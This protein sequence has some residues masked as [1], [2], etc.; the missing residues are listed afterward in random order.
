VARGSVDG[1]AD[2]QGAQE[3][4]FGAL[5]IV[6]RRIIRRPSLPAA[7]R[8]VALSEAKGGMAMRHEPLIRASRTFS[9]LR[10]A[11]AADFGCLRPA[12]SPSRSLQSTS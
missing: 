5:V 7:G 4:R 3:V 9:P 11:K 6:D 10:G 12:A 2:A 1:D 8:N